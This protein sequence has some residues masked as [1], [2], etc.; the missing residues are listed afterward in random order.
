M[1]T[2]VNSDGTLSEQGAATTFG[3]EG[4]PVVHAAPTQAAT[5]TA[6][7][8][9]ERPAHWPQDKNE[10]GSFKVT[11]EAEMA[12]WFAG[13]FTGEGA[14]KVNEPEAKAPAVETPKAPEPKPEETKPAEATVLT[15]EQIATNLKAAGGIYADEKYLPFAI[16]VE[17]TGALTPES[18]AKAAADFGVPPEFVK[19]FV[20]GQLATKELATTKAAQASTAAADARN[21]AVADTILG[22]VKDASAYD[23]MMT[24]AH[25][26][27]N[28]NADTQ[29]AFNKA[30]DSGD[31]DTLKVLT[32][33]IHDAWQAAPG[34]SVRRD[35]TRGASP[36]QIQARQAPAAKPFG[37]MDEQVQAQGSRRYQQDQGYRDEV[38]ARIAVSVYRH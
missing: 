10:D 18:L 20:D 29:K 21:K 34:G 9:G 31:T 16:E 15:D 22:V 12:T 24:W 32:K 13:A 28:V 11:S 25:D 19:T 36:E 23:T 37:S 33:S 7:G 30:L 2:Q 17:R 5:D 26:T 3:N 27:A 8:G 35:I 14:P 6:L 4:D 38:N 1:S